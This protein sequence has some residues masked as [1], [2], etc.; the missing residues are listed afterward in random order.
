MR[1]PR[2]RCAVRTPRDPW[3]CPRRFM[4]YEGCFRQLAMTCAAI[5]DGSDT[6]SLSLGD[7]LFRY[8]LRFRFPILRWRAA[9]QLLVA[10]RA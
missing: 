5:A 2:D 10:G 4:D 9:G 1:R 6:A 7:D 3:W 8:S